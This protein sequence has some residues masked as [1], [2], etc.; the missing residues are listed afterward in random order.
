MEGVIV[1]S[2]FV[3]LVEKNIRDTSRLIEDVTGF[4]REM[5]LATMVRSDLFSL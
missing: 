5:K 2:A 4:A 1:A 3:K